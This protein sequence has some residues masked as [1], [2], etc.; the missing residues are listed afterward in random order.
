MNSLSSGLSTTTFS[1]TFLAVSALLLVM[2]HYCSFLGSVATRQ[3]YI[4]FNGNFMERIA[5]AKLTLNAYRWLVFVAR[6]TR[7]CFFSFFCPLTL[8]APPPFGAFKCFNVFHNADRA[9]A[10][11]REEPSPLRWI[12]FEHL[13]TLRA[14]Q[15][16][17]QVRRTFST[18]YCF[19]FTTSSWLY[20]C[21]GG[22]RTFKSLKKCHPAVVER[23]WSALV[24][25]NCEKEEAMGW[26]RKFKFAFILHSRGL[27]SGMQVNQ[28]N[29]GEIREALMEQ[30]MY[31]TIT[32]EHG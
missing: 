3:S 29:Y 7:D 16:D 27:S 10:D 21:M 17:A 14:A 32:S 19:R 24:G 6:R 2:I 9:A 30:F 5:E 1:T 25:V 8:S 20:A 18:M 22:M 23:W 13:T 4:V 15:R 26:E 11:F 12:D 31:E 28:L